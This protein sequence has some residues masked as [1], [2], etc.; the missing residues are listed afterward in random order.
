M[1]TKS[2]QLSRGV[3]RS[4]YL[5]SLQNFPFNQQQALH[6]K[7]ASLTGSTYLELLH[8]QGKQLGHKK[9]YFPTH[10]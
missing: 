8:K 10:K 9:V 1:L 3:V 5:L 7:I 4:V 2:R 6:R